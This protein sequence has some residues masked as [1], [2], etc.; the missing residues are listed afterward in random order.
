MSGWAWEDSHPG[1]CAMLSPILTCQA[2]WPWW[3]HPLIY[4]ILLLPEL[5][6][7][8]NSPLQWR[9]QML[10]YGGHPRA[11]GGGRPHLALGWG[12]YSS[13]GIC[14][15]Q[16]GPHPGGGLVLRGWSVRIGGLSRGDRPHPAHSCWGGGSLW[17][18][19]G[20]PLSRE[21]GG[22]I[23][24][25]VQRSGVGHWRRAKSTTQRSSQWPPWRRHACAGD[26]RR[27]L[28]SRWNWTNSSH[29]PIGYWW[30]MRGGEKRTGLSR[31]L[32]PLSSQK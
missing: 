26:I 19:R 28:C 24:T 3:N 7:V 12:S 16:W 22:G 11:F 27:R 4:V 10:W 15:G 29:G 1:L 8:M 31:V 6:H 14:Q 2:V 32:C 20:G 30:L 13:L 5:V 25:R 21:R 18:W 17:V 23:S 9:S